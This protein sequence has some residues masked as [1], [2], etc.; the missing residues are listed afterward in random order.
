[1]YCQIWT[2]NWWR[3]M[4]LTC[5][6]W[7][8]IT[9]Q[10]MLVF[11]SSWWFRCSTL[12][13]G[14]FKADLLWFW[15]KILWDF[16]VSFFKFFFVWLNFGVDVSNGN[17]KDKSRKKGYYFEFVVAWI[18]FFKIRLL[19]RW[20]LLVMRWL[21]N[22]GCWCVLAIRGGGIYLCKAEVRLMIY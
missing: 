2:W 16:L 9:T 6:C 11:G 8:L 15:M 21:D 20:W 3:R 19:L 22:K 14:W 7:N 12:F 4:L 10:K 18:K 13:K 17:K 5:C 1:M